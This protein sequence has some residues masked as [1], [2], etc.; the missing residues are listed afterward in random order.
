MKSLART[1]ELEPPPDPFVIMTGAE[2]RDKCQAHHLR[3][4]I[5]ADR[6]S[7]GVRD[8]IHR[9]V[10][11]KKHAPA[12]AARHIVGAGLRSAAQESAD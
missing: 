5:L 8:L 1:V 12:I 4:K 9:G 11:D 2:D 6:G 3:P 10:T 7:A